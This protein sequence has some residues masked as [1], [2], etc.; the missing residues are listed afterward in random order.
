MGLFHFAHQLDGSP[1]QRPDML[2]LNG[3]FSSGLFGLWY[4]GTFAASFCFFP[5]YLINMLNRFV[6]SI[7]NIR[8]GNEVIKCRLDGG[9]FWIY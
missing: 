2:S 1:E 8:M 5:D 9:L 6:S 3:S 4:S 7:D